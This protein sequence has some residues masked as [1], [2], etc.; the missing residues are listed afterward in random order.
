[1]EAQEV[2]NELLKLILTKLHR[3]EKRFNEIDGRLGSFENSIPPA[4]GSIPPSGPQGGQP[5]NVCS[6]HIPQQGFQNPQ[7]D[8]ERRA[9][10]SSCKPSIDNVRN[11]FEFDDHSEVTPYE[12]GAST[13]CNGRNNMVEEDDCYSVSIYPYSM[14]T[15]TYT[16]RRASCPTRPLSFASD[17][18]SCAS[19]PVSSSSRPASEFSIQATDMGEPCE[20]PELPSL[21][22]ED[23]PNPEESIGCPSGR[24]S[25]RSSFRTFSTRR[26][27]VSTARTSIAL[28]SYSGS[29]PSLASFGKMR[30]S[31][32]QPS[33]AGLSS[34]KTSII[35]TDT[36]T[37]TGNTTDEETP[38]PVVERIEC[39]KPESPNMGRFLQSFHKGARACVSY[40]F[41]RK[42]ATQQLRTF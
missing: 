31:I 28:S 6:C 41:G 3:L 38:A 25:I 10:S 26:K 24:T 20:I 34:R 14:R 18:A 2:N 30:G 40:I 16:S 39:A 13:P 4:A 29:P 37:T 12:A 23:I 27:S 22:Y 1:M 5:P 32:R 21:R 33:S 36:T 15:V 7:V 42:A 9:G 8:W 35:D 11:R 17:P 19:R